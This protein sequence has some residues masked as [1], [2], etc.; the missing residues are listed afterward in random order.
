[1]DKLY[2][3]ELMNKVY[4]ITLVY[5]NFFKLRSLFDLLFI[6]RIYG[7]GRDDVALFPLVDPILFLLC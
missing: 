5:F 1:M 6:K 7:H 3:I 2:K 4:N